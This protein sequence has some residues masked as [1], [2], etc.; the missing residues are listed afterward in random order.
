MLRQIAT[1]EVVDVMVVTT[2]VVEVLNANNTRA[3]PLGAL[4]PGSTTN[5]TGAAW[6]SSRVVSISDA[7]G[8]SS[9][10]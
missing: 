5:G 8:F 1:N 9:S 4:N 2:V 7:T 10:L 6:R 3:F